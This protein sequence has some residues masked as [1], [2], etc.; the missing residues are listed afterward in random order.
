MVPLNQIDLPRVWKTLNDVREIAKDTTDER[1]KELAPIIEFHA[2]AINSQMLAD[3]QRGFDE[4]ETSIVRTP[5]AA[6]PLVDLLEDV[7]KLATAPHPQERIGDLAKRCASLLEG[8]ISAARGV[9]ADVVTVGHMIDPD[10][11]MC[12]ALGNSAQGLLDSINLQSELPPKEGVQ[13][14]G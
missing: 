11:A 5:E 7:A 9:L 12:R 3:G 4:A 8:E 2:D 13:T 10:I 1:L 6:S 14:G